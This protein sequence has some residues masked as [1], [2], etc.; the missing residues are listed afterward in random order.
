MVSSGIRKPRFT[1]AGTAKSAHMPSNQVL[2]YLTVSAIF[3]CHFTQSKNPKIMSSELLTPDCSPQD[4]PTPA[5]LQHAPKPRILAC[6]LCQQ[7]KIKCD[8]K[9][10]C[11]HCIKSGA[12]CMSAALAPRQRRRR[13]PERELLDRLRQYED[14]LR[15]NNIPFE[16]LHPSDSGHDA[17][18]SGHG[19]GAERA[20][21]THE[22]SIGTGSYGN[23]TLYKAKNFWHAMN[24]TVMLLTQKKKYYSH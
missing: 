20:D 9:F 11:A 1:L 21:A 16:P 17:T 23:T 2:Y 22:S 19:G 3:D 15:Q 13:F 8:R 14:L 5:H 12:Q 4:I 18:I 10:P 7:R 24:R 6:L